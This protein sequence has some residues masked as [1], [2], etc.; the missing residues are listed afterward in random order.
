MNKRD[1]RVGN[2]VE[3]L[4]ANKKINLPTGQFGTIEEIREEK[5]KIKLRNESSN[6]VH[7][8]NRKYDTIKPIKLT[9]DWML[10]LGFDEIDNGRYKYWNFDFIF[11]FYVNGLLESDDLPM[12][13]HYEYVHEIQNLYYDLTGDEF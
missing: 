2:L 13:I 7:V 9:H 11:Y 12:F 8:F 4:T 1:L 10:K 5:V 3:I 6:V